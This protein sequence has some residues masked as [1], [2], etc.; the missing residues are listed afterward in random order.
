MIPC[1]LVGNVINDS[2]RFFSSTQKV[3]QLF[4]R[5]VSENGENPYIRR[6][7]ALT[8]KVEFKNVSFK[9]DKITL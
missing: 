9:Y 4:M 3:M 6:R 2:Q 8:R 5:A 1:V 7:T